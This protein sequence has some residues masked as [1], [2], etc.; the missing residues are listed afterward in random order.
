MS[1]EFEKFVRKN[2]NEFDDAVPP[3]KIWKEVEKTIP[4]KKEAKRKAEFS[5]LFLIIPFTCFEK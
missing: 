5:K 4:V 2:R 1:S 3:D